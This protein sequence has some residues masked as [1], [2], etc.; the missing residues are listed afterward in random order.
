MLL[1]VAV[2]LGCSIGPRLTRTGL[3]CTL[4]SFCTTF[5]FFPLVLSLYFCF[6]PFTLILPPTSRHSP[7]HPSS[8]PSHLTRLF[9]TRPALRCRPLSR[10]LILNGPNPSLLSLLW[11][12]ASAPSP[13][14]SGRHRPSTKQNAEKMAAVKRCVSVRR[15]QAV[16]CSVITEGAGTWK[17]AEWKGSC[18][19]CVSSVSGL[20]P[21][22]QDYSA[23]LGVLKVVSCFFCIYFRPEGWIWLYWR[24]AFVHVKEI[25]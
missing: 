12:I 4:C 16:S 10:L 17:P 8:P 24:Y 22:I 14:V 18:Q 23:D 7:T 2:Y 15:G 13:P 25:N 20:H 1:S 5:Y 21:L 9:H 19:Q 11:M 3:I 6:S